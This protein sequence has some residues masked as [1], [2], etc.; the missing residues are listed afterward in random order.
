MTLKQ[1]EYFLAIAETGSITQ[2]A[3]RLHVSQPPLSL[4]LKALE[5]ELGVPLFERTKRGLV[6]TQSGRLLVRRT[7][8]ILEMLNL[9][10][11][12][13]RSKTTSP[14]VAIRVGTVNSV[15]SRLF[16]DWI[17]AYQCQYPHVDIQVSEESTTDILVALDDHKIDIGIVREPF[18]KDR[19]NCR[20]IQDDALE[21]HGQDGFVA[22]ADPAFYAGFEQNAIPLSE[23][24]DF[25]LL[26]HRRYI[27]MFTEYCKACGFIPN[28]ICK[29]NDALSLLSWAKAGI[30]IAVLPFS[31][32]LLSMD[33]R[34][35]RKEIIDP[36]I[37]SRVFAAWNRDVKLSE[38]AV[39]FLELITVPTG[40]VK[41]K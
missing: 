22:L 17:Y 1:L 4:Q 9:T 19:Y 8:E 6:I 12:E 23:L 40:T 31:A 35:V 16:P 20:L 24:R 27:S 25:P 2:A 30:G 14:K 33:S 5:D 37:P 21:G 32:S 3:E 13:V 38:E 29:N 39:R 10:V 36:P 28:I 11:N 15:S 18:N 7:Q 26:L 41:Q 34:L